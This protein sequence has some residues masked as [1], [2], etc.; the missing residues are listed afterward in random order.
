MIHPS[1]VAVDYIYEK[2]AETYLPDEATRT[3]EEVRK[4]KKSLSHSPLHPDSDEYE[5][6]KHKLSQQLEAITKK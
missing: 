2:F 1:E 5:R 6:F 4:I 3:S